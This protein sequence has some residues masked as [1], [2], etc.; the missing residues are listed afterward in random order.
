MDEISRRM[1]R[2]CHNFAFGDD[3][4]PG[5][6]VGFSQA[7]VIIVRESED[8]HNCHLLLQKHLN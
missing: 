6:G 5:G 4:S 7:S 2:R 1:N 8:Q 3:V